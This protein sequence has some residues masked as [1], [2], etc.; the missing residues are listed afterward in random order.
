[1]SNGKKIHVDLYLTILPEY[2]ISIDLNPDDA[3]LTV[4]PGDEFT[5]S[6]NITNEG[7]VEDKI[8]RYENGQIHMGVKKLEVYNDQD[9]CEL[10]D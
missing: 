7:N 3:K 6:V 1:M 10:G 5:L 8:A 9:Q 2:K 4:H